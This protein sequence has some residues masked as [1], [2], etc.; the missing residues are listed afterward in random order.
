MTSDPSPE[1]KA[2]D[3]HRGILSNFFWGLVFREPLR[4]ELVAENLVLLTAFCMT[5]DTTVELL[6]D[7]IGLNIPPSNEPFTT[8]RLTVGV[9]ATTTA[10]ALLTYGLIRGGH[11][12]VLTR[13][14]VLR[15]LC[16]AILLAVMGGV[17]LLQLWL[18]VF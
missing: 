18:H 13:R 8:L 2:D 10:L 9:I 14:N 3:K 12:Q 4:G 11:E 17:L 7:F 5:W 6:N 1:S 16:M 15:S